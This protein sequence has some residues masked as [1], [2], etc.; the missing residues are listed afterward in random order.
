MVYAVQ[1]EKNSRKIR[2]SLFQ[3][4][5]A[6]IPDAAS[7]VMISY[8]KSD[9]RG[10]MYDKLENGEDAFLHDGNN[11]FTIVLAEQVLTTPGNVSLIISF[12]S[13][14]IIS[15]SFPIEVNVSENPGI[16]VAESNDYFN[17]S[18][19]SLFLV[20]ISAVD[21]QYIA[22]KKFGE[23]RDAWEMGRYCVCNFGDALLPLVQLESDTAWFTAV[24]G[25]REH[26]VSISATAAVN[27]D[28]QPIGA[29]GGGE[30]FTVTLTGNLDECHSDKTFA[31]ILEAVDAG[32]VVQ[33]R[34]DAWGTGAY[35]ILPLVR[36]NEDVV[37]F[38]R[39]L[40]Y[41]ELQ[42]AVWP[43]NSAT[44]GFIGVYDAGA[45]SIATPEYPGIVQPVAKS[46]YMTQSVG[47]DEYG[48]LWT[49]PG[50]GA[51]WRYLDTFDLSSGAVS[52]ETDTT[53]CNEI[54]LLVT[55]ELSNGGT[56]SWKGFSAVGSVAAPS[57]LSKALA[58]VTH[59]RYMSDGFVIVQ[60]PRNDSDTL[61]QSSFA[62]D[63]K[64][65]NH[66]LKLSFGT[67]T[68]GVVKVYGR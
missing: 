62:V 65:D 32:R 19:T 39:T 31:E 63:A 50:G 43:D 49:V 52:Y 10:G 55:A 3:N 7:N 9:G 37:E 24:W 42:A 5:S 34:S 61:Q 23:I 20:T 53:G 40:E 22:D 64:S 45:I 17:L 46:E 11:V 29:D 54:L 30:V 36:A 14:D 6:W 18:F 60:K 15:S 16:D 56:V 41:T 48:G 35:E 66:A 51:A 68:S 8:K 28:I 13:D 12:V 4:G 25:K 47:V 27:V 1:G 33:C 58:G 57:G 67:A 2:V 44:V 21:G 59:L 38:G 26:T